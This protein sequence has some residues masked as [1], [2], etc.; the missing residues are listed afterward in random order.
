MSLFVA[1]L[2]ASVVF[3]CKIPDGFTERQ[4]VQVYNDAGG[5]CG[6]TYV[7]QSTNACDAYGIC[8]GGGW[9]YVSKSNKEGFG[10]MF[11]SGGRPHYFNM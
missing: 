5:A 6:S 8:Y 11:W 9:Y 7:Y 4:V 2:L 10:Y 3:A 1:I